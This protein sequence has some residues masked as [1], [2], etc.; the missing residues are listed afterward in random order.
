MIHKILFSILLIVSVI[1]GVCVTDAPAFPYGPP[2]PCFGP[3]AP[4][5]TPRIAPIVR[6]HCPSALFPPAPPLVDPIVACPVP[7]FCPPMMPV[8]SKVRPGAYA[9]PMAPTHM[10]PMEAAVYRPMQ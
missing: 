3:I 7:A 9:A 5:P 8:P 6:D 10:R 2:T 1:A 4:H